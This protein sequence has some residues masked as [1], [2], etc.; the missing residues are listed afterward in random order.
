M[1][2]QV[3]AAT[4]LEGAGG[5]EVLVLDPGLRPQEPGES[6]VVAKRRGAEVGLDAGAGGKDVPEGRQVHVCG[7]GSSLR[8]RGVVD[9]V[10]HER[11]RT[12]ALEQLARA[13]A[14]R[15]LLGRELEIHRHPSLTSA[16]G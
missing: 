15:L 6:R 10:S 16:S 5:L 2:H 7:T 14:Q 13:G 11:R 4:D 9:D 8:S 3:Q 1:R 12:L